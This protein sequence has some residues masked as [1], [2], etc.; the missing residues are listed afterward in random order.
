MLKNMSSQTN[1]LFVLVVLIALCQNYVVECIHLNSV[2]AVIQHRN[3]LSPLLPTPVFASALKQRD[4]EDN[5]KR[6]VQPKQ[7]TQSPKEICGRLRDSP[8]TVKLAKWSVIDIKDE[9]LKQR[10]I[11][12]ALDDDIDDATIHSLKKEA[13]EYR[14][15]KAS[16]EREKNRLA[17]MNN[18]LWKTF[19]ASFDKFSRLPVA[20]KLSASSG[21]A[22]FCSGM[23]S[24]TPMAGV[25]NIGLIGRPKEW[26]KKSVL[27]GADWARVSAYYTAG[28]TFF[29]HV[30]QKDDR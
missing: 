25:L 4:K 6:K 9:K 28:E 26:I 20:V 3:I 24:L 16:E 23:I 18:P 10:L 11:D 5:D 27:T 30:R 1:C 17:R 29:R 21:V 19:D 2:S 13:D 7:Q 14:T 15:K 12:A 22:S 8:F